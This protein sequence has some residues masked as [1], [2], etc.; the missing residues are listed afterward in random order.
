[1]HIVVGNV[2]GGVGKTTSSVYI[3]AAAAARGREPVLL[4]DSDP[5]GSAAEW[6]EQNPVEGVDLVEAPS[7]RTV[8]RALTN[9][10]G[11]VVVDTPPGDE[12]IVR[13][14]LR[15]ADAVVIPTRAGGVE[16]SRVLA[17]L[18]MTPEDIPCG[19]V[20]CAARLGTNDLDAT[21]EDWAS[22]KI[23]VWGVVPER[24]AIAAGPAARI[25]REGLEV[26]QEVLRRALRAARG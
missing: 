13:A 6:F 2:K 12:R 21:V 8:V 11:I 23:P 17:T 16:P 18:E 26:Y 3:A 14:A 9:S 22:A 10:T 19:V 7:E 15:R 4:V 25:S 5:Q 20:V 1:M 24:V